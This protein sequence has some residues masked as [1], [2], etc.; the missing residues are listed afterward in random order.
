DEPGLVRAELDPELDGL[1]IG[2]ELVDGRNGVGPDRAGAAAGLIAADGH[3]GAGRLDVAAIV[4]GST[5]DGDLR[6][7]DRSPDVAPRRGASSRMPDGAAVDGDFH[8]TD[9]ATSVRGGSADRDRYVRVQVRAGRGRGD[10]RN[11][12]SAV[13]R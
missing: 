1:R 10:R 6:G 2:H 3:P 11:R 7:R 8:S 12:R 13:G 4:D 9:Q 5:A